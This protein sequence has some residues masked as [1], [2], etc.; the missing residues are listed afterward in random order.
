MNL[1]KLTTIAILGTSMLTSTA[2]FAGEAEDNKI[3]E[4]V[5]K[6]LKQE[7]DLPVKEIQVTTTN[8]I[9]H[10]SGK[11]DTQSQVNRAIEVAYSVNDVADVEDNRLE[12]KSSDSFIRDAII[13]AKAKGKILQLSN[14]KQI[15]KH[16]N[17]HVETLN[18]R[19]HIEGKVGR[20]GDADVIRDAL[21][22]I[23]HVKTVKFA[24]R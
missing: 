1:N 4:E 7:K 5:K 9:V 20:L 11:V 23:K 6:L 12:T 2:M 16:Y 15:S 8:N 24:V 3:T 13:T 18:G 19:I 22:K 21:S 17:L 10:L 14:N